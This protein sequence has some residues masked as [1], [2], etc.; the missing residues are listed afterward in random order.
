MKNKVLSDTE[1]LLRKRIRELEAENRK[2]KADIRQLKSGDNIF[3]TL[4]NQLSAS[5]DL[6]EIN[7]ELPPAIPEHKKWRASDYPKEWEPKEKA[8]KYLADF[9]KTTL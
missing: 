8:C 6:G 2:L 7:K 1:E 3:Y 9:W 4:K 5:V